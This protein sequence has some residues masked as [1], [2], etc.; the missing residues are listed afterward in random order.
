M[1]RQRRISK[2]VCK[3]MV[4]QVHEAIVE[5]ISEEHDYLVQGRLWSQAPEIDGLTYLS[6]TRPLEAGEIVKVKIVNSHDYDL[7]GEVLEAD[8]PQAAY[9]F[10]VRTRGGHQ[11][12]C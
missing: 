5:G 2:E 1:R 9:P 10:D 6:S 11:H 7:V 3:T 12:A 8:D 4:G